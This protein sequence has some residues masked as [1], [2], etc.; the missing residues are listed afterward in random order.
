MNEEQQ[1]ELLRLAQELV[2]H[3]STTYFGEDDEIGACHYC[4][5]VSFEKH[6]ATCEYKLLSNFLD[7]Q[8][9]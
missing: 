8:H 6:E 5:S 3:G 2:D 1:A 4:G 7:E 9:S